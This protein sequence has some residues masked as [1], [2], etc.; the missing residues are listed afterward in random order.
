MSA[1]PE[2][3]AAYIE[4]LRALA[5]VLQKHDEVP[6]PSNGG[7]G[8][9]VFNFW[10]D[11]AKARMAAV[12]RAFPVTWRK[13]AWEAASGTAYFELNATL[14]GLPLQLGAH[15][16]TVCERIVTG[17]E[18]REVEEEVEPAKTR[19]VVKKVETVEWRCTPLLAPAVSPEGGE[20]E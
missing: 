3:R 12:A 9:I 5:D 19:K 1:T 20:G 15:R 14:H 7:T 6:L 16:D 18:E 2:Q 17:I 4:G 8:T 11:D 13:H 10:S